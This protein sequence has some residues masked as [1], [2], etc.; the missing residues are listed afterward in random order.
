M[1]A[2][3]CLLKLE[4]PILFVHMKHIVTGTVLS[5]PEALL[6]TTERQNIYYSSRI[7]PD[8]PIPRETPQ[9]VVNF[10]PAWH[11]MYVVVSIVAEDV[12]VSISKHVDGGLTIEENPC[13][14]DGFVKRRV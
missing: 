3:S 2:S 13:V 11:L 12:S 14:R 5:N 8:P 6:Y 9:R 7:I 4:D 1:Q 10:V